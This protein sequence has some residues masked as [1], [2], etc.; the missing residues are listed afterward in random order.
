MRATRKE[1]EMLNEVHSPDFSLVKGR[2]TGPH[3]EILRDV[4]ILGSWRLGRLKDG[5]C[6]SEVDRIVAFH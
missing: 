1:E 4:C 2:E 3:M 6:L 5:L